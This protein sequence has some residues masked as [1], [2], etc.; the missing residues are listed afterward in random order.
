MMD[1]FVVWQLQGVRYLCLRDSK[2]ENHHILERIRR[3]PC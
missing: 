3:L 2:P 1:H